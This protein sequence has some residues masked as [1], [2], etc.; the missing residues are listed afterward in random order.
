MPTLLQRN[1]KIYS[2]PE[3]IIGYHP[4]DVYGVGTNAAAFSYFRADDGRESEQ[5]SYK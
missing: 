4:Y 3:M 5:S 1:P 2:S